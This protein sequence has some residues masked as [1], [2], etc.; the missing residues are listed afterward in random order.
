MSFKQAANGRPRQQQGKDQQRHREE[1]AEM[2]TVAEDE[3]NDLQ[4]QELVR[5]PS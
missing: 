2:H 4:D 5:G 3:G 1:A